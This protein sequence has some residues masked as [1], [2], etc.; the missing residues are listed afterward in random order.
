MCWRG[1]RDLFAENRIRPDEVA[2]RRRRPQR[3]R[4]MNLIL[5][6]GVLITLATGIPVFLQLT[7]NHP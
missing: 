1:S 3:K 5:L 6:L 2:S 7:R 4:C